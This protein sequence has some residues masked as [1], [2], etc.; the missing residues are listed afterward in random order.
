[1]VAGVGSSL[2]SSGVVRG[3][4]G[5]AK[6]LVV[7]MVT[8]LVVRLLRLVGA[9]SQRRRLVGWWLPVAPCFV[10]LLRSEDD[11]YRSRF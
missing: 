1:M 2:G 3:S 10:S 9:G 11:A 6:L 7:V 4:L 5:S 8:W